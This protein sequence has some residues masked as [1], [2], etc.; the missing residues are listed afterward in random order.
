MG[1]DHVAIAAGAGKP[2]I[3][4][5]KN[6][7]IRG[8]RKASDFLMA[9]QLTGAVKRDSLANLQVRLPAIV[10]GG[11]LTGIDTTTEAAAYY[12]VQVEKFLE[13]WETLAGASG[14]KTRCARML[15]RRGGGDRARVPRA[16]ARGARRAGARRGRRRG[17]RLQRSWWRRGAASRWSTARAMQDSPAYR[18]N[19]EEIIKFFEE[20]VALHREAVA[21]RLRPRRARR[22]GRC[23]E[24]CRDRGTTASKV[25]LPARTLFVAAGTSPNVTYE[26]ERPGS[27]EID[28][29][30]KGF[31]AFR[32]VHGPDGDGKLRLEPADRRADRL[33]HQLPPRR[34]HRHASTATTTR[35]TPARWC[36]RWRRRRTA[37]RTSRRCSRASI[38]GAAIPTEQPARDAAWRAFAGKLD[39]E[40]AADGRTGRAADADHRRGGGARARRPRATSSR[41]SSSACRTSRR[42]RA[43]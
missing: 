32:A 11:G 31:Q 39:D 28:P 20:G 6:N 5:V 9:L 14:A 25:T 40:L 18:L 41:G 10:I 16:R 37:R 36:A 19:H 38:A 42:C 8:V 29:R 3:I 15:R 2:T 17:A 34:A 27:F 4:D 21:A 7:L 22:A 35:A 33:L 26:R 1:F 43:R 30:T 12:P 24:R 23:V 13:R